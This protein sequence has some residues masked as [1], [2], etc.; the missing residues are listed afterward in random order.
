M[1]LTTVTQTVVLQMLRLLA[2]PETVIHAGAGTGSGELHQWQDWSIPR[3]IIIDAELEK[4]GWATSLTEDNPEWHVASVVLAD[5]DK[6]ATFFRASNPDENGLLEPEKLANIWPNLKAT[7]PSELQTTCL[8][9]LLADEQF[10]T[11][12]G[13][14]WGIIDCLPALKILRGAE[15]TL[16]Q[17]SVLWL[18]VTF[19]PA[20]AEDSDLAAIESFLKPL[21]FGCISIQ[22]GNHPKI[23]HALFVK[24]WQLT[25]QP[26][27]DQLSQTNTELLSQTDTLRADNNALKAEEA[28]LQQQVTSLTEAR[29]SYG[30]QLETCKNQI[31]QLNQ[32][33]ADLLSQT[34]TLRVNNAALKAEEAKLQQQ[35]TSLTEARDSYGAQLEMSKTQL[36]ERDTKITTLTKERDEQ[37]KLATQR[38]SDLEQ[39][40]VKLKEKETRVAQL[41]S[42]QAELESRQQMLND[43]MIRAEAQIDLIKDV[44]LREPG[45]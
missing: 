16:N 19:E 8:D 20:I 4:L 22:A 18:R 3:A 24:N 39:S 37:T 25:L 2:P 11:L 36:A 1:S 35:V 38:K 29:D 12:N 9:T 31:D 13:T 40:Q 41:E 44:L 34:D 32:A 21:G 7:E 45:L 28:K 42:S 10:N 33:N 5:T 15:K 6:N 30:A 14:C 27:I 26:Q 17:L 23:G 43:E